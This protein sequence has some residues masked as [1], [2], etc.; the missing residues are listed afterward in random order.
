MFNN[1]KAT[2]Y[3]NYFLSEHKNS[4]KLLGGSGKIIISAPHSV[5]QWRNGKLK[6]AERETGVLARLLHDE[7]D[8]PVIFKTKNCKDDA[9]FDEKAAYKDD[10]TE[11]IQKN[12]VKF[13]IDLHQLSPSR[14]VMF[15]I[16]TANLSTKNGNEILN[17]V[18]KVLTERKL[19]IIQVNKLHDGSF[20]FT[21]S[22]HVAKTCDIPSL[23]LEMNTKLLWLG[24]RGCK[25]KQVY[26][27]LESFILEIEKII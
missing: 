16:G 3:E 1:E 6:S 2:E 12:D 23:Q 20:R 19:G 26:E 7:L 17:L 14:E 11:Y 24:K 5:S 4:H 15:D 21:V 18:L 22:S 9:N 25:L 8:L 27:A 13:L 10:L